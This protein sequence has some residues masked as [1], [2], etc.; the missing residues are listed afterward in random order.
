VEWDYKISDRT[1]WQTRVNGLYASR[2]AIGY[3]PNRP[4]Q[5]DNGG[6][7]DLMKGL[8]RNVTMESRFMHRYTFREQ[9]NTLLMGVRAYY[10]RTI[11][12]QGFV[13]NGTGPD[14][15]YPNESSDLMSD[16]ENPNLNYAAFAENIFRFGPQ[17]S[18]T[19]GIRAE[20]IR[21][22]TKGYFRDRQTDLAGN[23][24]VDN[25]QYDDK[26]LPRTFVLGGVGLSYKPSDKVEV[27]GNMSQ[28]YRS[29]TFSDIR[30][31]NPSFEIDPNI[32][33]ERGWS[34]DLGSRGG[35]GAFR[36]DANVFFLFYG[37]RIGE[38]FYKTPNYMVIR[39]RG[40]LGEANVYGLESYLELNAM[41][42][43][44]YTGEKWKLNIYSNFALTEATYTKSAMPD[45]VG[46]RVEY[47]PLVNWRSGIQT[48]Y[49]NFRLTLQY[50]MLTE[51]YAD[52]TNATDGGFS[53]V[54]GLIPAYNI[55]DVSAGYTWKRYTIEATVNNVLNAAYFTRRATAYPGPG[56]IPGDGR[57]FFVTLGVKI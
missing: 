35:K 40:N 37:N 12:R 45:V 36:Y 21:T 29:V 43:A 1:R 11:A 15:N 28:N 13:D 32:K 4:S 19:P 57:A 6:A 27:Y 14:F 39:R 8:F 26:Q 18:I 2:D 38:Y 7:R 22:G 55:A 56:I 30:T 52:A 25:L 16:Y 17:F 44:G 9:Q 41:K 50:S 48:H 53:A 31:L 54:N 51:Q 24:I 46:K 23:V 5:V 49:R 42:L 10:G 33:D 47:V 34:A 20:Y 3:R